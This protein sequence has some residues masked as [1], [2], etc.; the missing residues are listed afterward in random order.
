VEGTTSDPSNSAAHFI[1]GSA[2][3]TIKAARFTMHLLPEQK[4][5]FLSLSFS[6]S[7]PIKRI[8]SKIQRG[9]SQ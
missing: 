1:K 8:K 3:M 5:A 4:K 9:G 6:I 2:G 7:C